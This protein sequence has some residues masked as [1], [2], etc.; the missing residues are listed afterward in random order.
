MTRGELICA[1]KEWYREEE[2]KT[3]SVLL[4]DM[5]RLDKMPMRIILIGLWVWLDVR[6]GRFA[7]VAA[8]IEFNVR[9][10]LLCLFIIGIVEQSILVILKLKLKKRKGKK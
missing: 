1:I 7:N 5:F 3:F 9:L 10:Y 6:D 2:G 8:S 4:K